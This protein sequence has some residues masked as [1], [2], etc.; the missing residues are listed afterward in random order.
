[1]VP[2]QGEKM[3]IGNAPWRDASWDKPQACSGLALKRSPDVNDLAS[4]CPVSHF[5]H[6]LGGEMMMVSQLQQYLTPSSIP[7]P[8][9]LHTWT[10]METEGSL[11]IYRLKSNNPREPY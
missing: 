8:V 1:M 11:L 6:F 4:Y 10:H 2:W 9:R 5:P 7:L 3:E